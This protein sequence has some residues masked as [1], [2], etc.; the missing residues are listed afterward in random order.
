LIEASLRAGTGGTVARF[1]GEAATPL[2]VQ[3]L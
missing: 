3:R 2:T 1:L